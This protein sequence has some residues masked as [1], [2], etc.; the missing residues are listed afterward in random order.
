VFCSERFGTGVADCDVFRECDAAPV[1]VSVDAGGGAV[2][3]L[4]G[5]VCS[6]FATD[7]YVLL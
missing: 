5:V 2:V 7:A 1:D 3:T 6:C 4:D